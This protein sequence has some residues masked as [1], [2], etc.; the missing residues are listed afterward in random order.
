M[1]HVFQFFGQDLHHD[2]LLISKHGFWPQSCVD[3]LASEA[4]LLENEGG[5]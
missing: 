5:S 4:R 3:V 2:S 1:E